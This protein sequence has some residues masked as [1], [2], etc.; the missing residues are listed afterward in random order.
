MIKINHLWDWIGNACLWKKCIYIDS[1]A[2]EPT[3]NPVVINSCQTKLRK[4]GKTL[5]KS[6][7][8]YYQKYI[9]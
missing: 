5:S 3:C 2:D 9:I 8:K 1:S 7:K 4:K 6:D